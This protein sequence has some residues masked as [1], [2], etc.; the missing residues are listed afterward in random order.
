MTILCTFLFIAEADASLSFFH[1]I[2]FFGPKIENK[3][4]LCSSFI[5]N[6]SGDNFFFFF[7]PFVSLQERKFIKLS[8]KDLACNHVNAVCSLN[9]KEM[10]IFRCFCREKCHNLMKSNKMWMCFLAKNQKF[11][12]FK[13]NV[14]VKIDFGLL[15][16]CF[17]LHSDISNLL[18]VYMHALIYKKIIQN[19]NVWEF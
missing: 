11:D 16:T 19:R 1:F 4:P 8:Q 17:K 15:N 13:N 2:F 9:I 3:I 7:S 12:F 5:T 14:V 6:H 10:I 18:F